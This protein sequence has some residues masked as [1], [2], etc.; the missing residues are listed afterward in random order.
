LRFIETVRGKRPVDKY[1]AVCVHEHLLIDLTH[2]ATVPKDPAEAALFNDTVRMENIGALRRNPYLVRENLILDNNDDAINELKFLPPTVGLI[3]DQT[4]VGIGRDAASLL[5]ISEASGIDIIASAGFFVE[6][7]LPP[8]ILDK[9]ADELTGILIN[10]IEAGIGGTGVKAGIIGEIGT[11]ETIRPVERRVLYAA[12]Q[13]HVQTGLPVSVHTYPWSRAGLEAVDLLI[14][15]NVKPS[16][17][18]VCHVDVRFDLEYMELLLDRGVYIEFDNFGKE[19][20]FEKREGA[21]AGGPFESD[22]ARVMMFKQLIGLGMGNRLLAAN[23]LCLKSMLRK[24]GGWGYDH[25][26]T[27]IQPMML[28]EGLNETDVSQILIK[29][30]INFLTDE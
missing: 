17:I 29:N 16:S 1:E 7:S 21:F 11:G 8:D 14:T 15:E 12:A 9:T 18:C 27:N 22:L 19:F 13:A 5:S 2:E 24:N 23:D 25:L 28:Q 6:E 10:E 3:V 4:C 30:P 26:F 20:Y